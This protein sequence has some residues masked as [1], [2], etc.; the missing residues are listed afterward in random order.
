[1]VTRLFDKSSQR[2]LSQ[3]MTLPHE[4]VAEITHTSGRFHIGEILSGET[5]E[6][7]C[8]PS[9]VEVRPWMLHTHPEA[10]Y[11]RQR[12]HFGW[13]SGQDIYSVLQHQLSL[14]VI[15]ALEGVYILQ[16]SESQRRDW[17]HLPKSEKKQII[18][19]MDLPGDK[20]SI[21]AFLDVISDL[22]WIDIEFYEH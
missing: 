4:M 12:V 20:G 13:P 22:G 7:A 1:M 6:G 21:D 3:W 16:T 10:C 19:Q 14:H 8:S 17:K 18:Q 9:H 11:R 15:V 2:L 5:P